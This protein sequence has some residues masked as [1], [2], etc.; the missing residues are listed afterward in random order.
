[1]NH[2]EANDTIRNAIASV[3]ESFP[4]DGYMDVNKDSYPTL[5]AAVLKHLPDGSRIL[6]FG[7]GPC[8]KTA[9][10]QALG[11]KCSACDDLLDAWYEAD[12]NREKVKTFATQAGIDFRVV[13]GGPLPFANETF[14][15]VMLL[16]V[17]EHLHDSPR[18]LLNDLLTLTKPEGL[19]LVSVPNAV[20]IRKRVQVL[21]GRT[22]LPPFHGYYWYPGPWRGHVREY[23]R[24]DL[25]SLAE[26]LGLEVLELRAVDHMLYRVPRA[27]RQAYLA[28]TAVCTGWK[29]SWMLIAKKPPG[30]IPR[31]ELPPSELKSIFG[32]HAPHSICQ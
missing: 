24:G 21:R 25:S 12:A 27:L 20:N 23:T 5:A 3:E 22:N 11:Y 9:I 18:D 26:Y 8:D 7:S 29:D 16:D 1:M 2:P 13:S 6:D 14:D 19:L 15:M 32:S 4:F 28:V 17:L 10:L 31:R 30:W